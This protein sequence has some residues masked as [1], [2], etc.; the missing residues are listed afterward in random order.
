[1]VEKESLLIYE[2]K[3]VKDQSKIYLHS[4]TYVNL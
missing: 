3:K 2:G 1:M 4:R